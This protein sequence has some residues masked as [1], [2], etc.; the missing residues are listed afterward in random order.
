MQVRSGAQTAHSSTVQNG[1]LIRRRCPCDSGW[2][3]VDGVV[4]NGCECAVTAEPAGGES[5]DTAID[6]GTIDDS[7]E[8]LTAEGSI[9][10]ADDQDWFRF[11]ATDTQPAGCDRFYVDVR[12]AENP[13]E[14]FAF[15]V[16]VGD[17]ATN[18]C[19]GDVLFSYATDFID[20]TGPEIRGECPCATTNTAGKNTCMDSSQTFYVRV[21]RVSV[22]SGGTC[23]GYSLIITNGTYST[24]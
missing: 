14:Q 22:S 5:C 3:D 11:T 4:G 24:P 13:E 20:T 8:S 6:L 9:V 7:G 1:V 23:D 16:F 12:F 17:C 18:M 10:P 15:E 19:A 21:R 2:A